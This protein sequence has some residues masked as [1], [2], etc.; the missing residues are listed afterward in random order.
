[1]EKS[2]EKEEGRHHQ[3]QRQSVSTTESEEVEQVRVQVQQEESAQRDDGI[4][5]APQDQCRKT[6]IERISEQVR[7][8]EPKFSRAAKHV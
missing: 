8:P 3:S 5:Q 4:G 6:K 2:Q 1:L 7:Q